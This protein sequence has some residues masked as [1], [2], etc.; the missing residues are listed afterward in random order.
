[1]AQ[2]PL[3][4]PIFSA[5]DFKLQENRASQLNLLYTASYFHIIWKLAKENQTHKQKLVLNSSWRYKVKFV[6][7]PEFPYQPDVG[8][9]SNNNNNNSND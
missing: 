7:H 9:H 1:M 6:P 8:Q 2:S 4:L 3:S 5:L